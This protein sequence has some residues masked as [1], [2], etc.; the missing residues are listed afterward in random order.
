MKDPYVYKG[1]LTQLLNKEV[2]DKIIVNTTTQP[3]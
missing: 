3:S 2:Q 1:W